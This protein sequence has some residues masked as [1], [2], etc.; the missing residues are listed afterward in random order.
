VKHVCNQ[1]KG[2]GCGTANAATASF[3]R[4]KSAVAFQTGFLPTRH[5]LTQ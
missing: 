5:P 3:M 2:Q 4:L 1:D